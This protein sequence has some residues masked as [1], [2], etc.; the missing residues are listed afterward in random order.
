MVSL[1]WLAHRD[2]VLDGGRSCSGPL[3]LGARLLFDR[4]LAERLG[5]SPTRTTTCSAAE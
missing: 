2:K 1:P 5:S 4:P 3:S